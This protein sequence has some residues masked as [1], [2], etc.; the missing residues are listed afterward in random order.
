MSHRCRGSEQQGRCFFF[1]IKYNLLSNWLP[2]STQCSSQQVPSSL[3]I[4][5]LPLPPIH[6][7]LLKSL[8]WFASLLLCLYLFF[9]FPSPTVFC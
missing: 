3:P 7:Q 6:P 4:P 2:H 5:H 1:F 8:L 9:P